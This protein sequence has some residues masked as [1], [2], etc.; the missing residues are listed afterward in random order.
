[1]VVAGGY[2]PE[3]KTYD[4]CHILDLTTLKWREVTKLP[5]KRGNLSLCTGH[6]CIYTSG[7]ITSW[8]KNSFTTDLTIGHIEQNFA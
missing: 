8:N 4:D 6:G 3:W 7:A 1:M 2:I 5:S